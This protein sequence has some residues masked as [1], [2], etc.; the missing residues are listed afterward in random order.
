[1]SRPASSATPSSS[2]RPCDSTEHQESDGRAAR[3]D[4]GIEA[5][6]V[7]VGQGALDQFDRHPQPRGR[8]E[9]PQE[10]AA[11]RLPPPQSD[12]EKEPSS[13]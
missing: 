11:L 8:R 9:R 6:R 7:P 4:D 10:V 5:L 13:A 1:M 2:S 3:I 12:G